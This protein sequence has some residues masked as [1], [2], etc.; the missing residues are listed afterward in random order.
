MLGGVCVCGDVSTVRLELNCP[1]FLLGMSL[2]KSPQPDPRGR[3]RSATPQL[4]SLGSPL[5]FYAML[6]HG[7]SKPL[8]PHVRNPWIL[9]SLGRRGVSC[10]AVCGLWG[11]PFLGHGLVLLAERLRFSGQLSP[12]SRCRNPAL[13]ASKDC[14]PRL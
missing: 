5:I 9:Q 4:P 7:G 3:V 8:Q 1:A 2:N 12:C 6:V 11:C 10:A 13:F 14:G